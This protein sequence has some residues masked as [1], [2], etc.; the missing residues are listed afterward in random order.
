MWSG[1]RPPKL[2]VCGG[3]NRYS[4]PPR[5][6]NLED[7]SAGESADT[8]GSRTST[9]QRV[10]S[11]CRRASSVVPPCGTLLIEPHSLAKPWHVSPKLAP[12]QQRIHRYYATILY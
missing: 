2:S 10:A 7:R 5:D 9:G 11:A 3:S 8:L 12:A 1:V 6:F 4:I